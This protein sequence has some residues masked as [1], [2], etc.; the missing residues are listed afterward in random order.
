MSGTVNCGWTAMCE[1]EVSDHL[2]KL[3]SNLFDGQQVCVRIDD[4]DNENRSGVRQGGILSPS[5]FNFL[6]RV[7]RALVD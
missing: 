4:E 7:R 3:I 2:I 5:L 1:L 6:S